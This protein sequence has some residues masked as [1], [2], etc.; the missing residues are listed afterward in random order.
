M[1][2]FFYFFL[3]IFSTHIALAQNSNLYGVTIEEKAID[4]RLN[5]IIEQ[6]YSYTTPKHE[7]AL[8]NLISES[9]KIGFEGGIL[10]GGH[11]LLILYLSNS[12]YKKTVELAS[13]L[14]KVAENK[15]DKYGYIST[16]YRTNAL[17]LGYLG[18][19]DASLKDFKKA[20]SSAEWIENDDRRRQQLAYTY[21]N[22]NVYYENKEKDSN[23]GDTILSNYQKSLELAKMIS[24]QNKEVK[25]NAKYG[26]IAYFSN[27]I[28]SFYLKRNKLDVAEKYILEALKIYENPKYDL[29]PTHKAETLN[30]LSKLYIRKKEYQKV[31]EHATNALK[32]ERQHSSPEVRKYSFELLLQAYLE[33]GD[34]EKAKFYRE[35]YTALNDSLNYEE[36][37]ASNSTMKKMVAE[38]KTEETHYTRKLLIAIGIAVVLSG[39]IATVLIIRRNR[40]LRKNYDKMIENLKNGSSMISVDNNEDNDA[41]ADLSSPT[42][43]ESG[44]TSSSKN[45]ISDQTEARILKDL[46]K[47][48]KSKN[49]LSKN[50]TISVLASQFNT[51][52]KYLSDIIKNN[53]SENFNHYINNL[54]INYIVHKLYNEPKYREFK[55]SYL[56]EE[57][58]FASPQVFVLAF[59]KINGVTP[60]Y[61]SKN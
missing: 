28:G 36:K 2:R 38:V 25:L 21:E 47:F 15:T 43:S 23:V 52:T 16:I 55:I 5:V 19:N 20:I 60:S 10:R 44:H 50:F 22:L 31:I 34:S 58:G 37:K 12:E 33:I 54:R 48:E 6:S 51:N 40:N 18:L 56:A 9:E 3:I 42:V 13:K 14:K 29:D 53:R 1:K 24:D 32:F 61:L 57:S 8:I 45:V 26:M 17:A 59:K 35:K 49:F 4:K 27:S 11:N 39:G 41:T 30:E 46:A 7:A